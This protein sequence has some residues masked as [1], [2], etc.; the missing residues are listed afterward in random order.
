[1]TAHTLLGDLTWNGSAL[2]SSD[3]A[4]SDWLPLLNESARRLAFVHQPTELWLRT[5]CGE[6]GL[7]V[8]DVSGEPDAVRGDA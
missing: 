1:M 7:F 6:C 2:V 3:A 4:L 5:V 8:V